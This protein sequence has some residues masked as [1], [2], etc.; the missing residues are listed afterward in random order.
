MNC[1][2]PLPC[3]E[4]QMPLGLNIVGNICSDVSTQLSHILLRECYILNL[5]TDASQS[6]LNPV[7]PSYKNHDMK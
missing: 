2:A 5:N 6:S 4:L 7:I 1:N 3:E